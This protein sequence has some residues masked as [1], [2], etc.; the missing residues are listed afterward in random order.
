MVRPPLAHCM[1]ASFGYPM[2]IAK[3]AEM[4]R[5]TALLVVTLLGISSVALAQSTEIPAV[6]RDVL[7]CRSQTDD[8]ARLRCYDAAVAR[9]ATSFESKSLVIV[10]KEKLKETRRGLFGLSLPRLP[11]L[12]DED[13]PEEEQI[14]ELDATV[15]SATEFGFQRWELDLGPAGT[16]QTIE[17]QGR[18]FPPSAG[19]KVKIKRGAL[20]SFVIETGARKSIKVKRVK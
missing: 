9:L 16:W 4:K 19:V 15:V 17:P 8:G 13:E 18:A 10:D 2:R 6:V 12:S 7:A 14:K 11:F 1:S 5:S 3:G 20:G